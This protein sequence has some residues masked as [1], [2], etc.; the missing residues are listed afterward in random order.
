M[1]DTSICYEMEKYDAGETLNLTRLKGQ[2]SK[3]FSLQGLPKMCDIMQGCNAQ[4]LAA[5]LLLV[6]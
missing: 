5:L 3:T 2:A 1:Q 6:V 4:P